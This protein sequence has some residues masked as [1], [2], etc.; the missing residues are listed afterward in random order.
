[1]SNKEKEYGK[2]SISQLKHAYS[3]LYRVRTDREELQKDIEQSSD[4]IQQLL[5]LVPP[6]SRWYEIPWEH[7]LSVFINSLGLSDTFKHAANSEDPQQTILDFVESSQDLPF[8]EVDLE[9]EEE[10][11]LL[12]LLLSIAGQLDAISIF[13]LP[14]SILVERAKNGDDNALFD[15]VLVDRSV[16]A[17]P[18]IARRIQMAD[19]LGDEAFLQQ[20]SKATTRTRPRRPAQEYDDLRVM[21]EALD[22]CSNL[23][24]F[25]YEKLYSL[26]VDELELYPDEGRKD[27]FSGLKKLIQRVKKAQGT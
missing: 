16:T 21:L 10:A 3:L 20:L 18:S 13:S 11:F 19:L 24:S 14:M 12:S 22:E 6:W 2:L 15:A 27:T 17:A 7:S 5:N 8:D 1:M 9:P 4:H 25:S 23:D 26:F